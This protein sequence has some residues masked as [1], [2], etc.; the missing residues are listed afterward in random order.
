MT[1]LDGVDTGSG[2]RKTLGPE[3]VIA[4]ILVTVNQTKKNNHDELERDISKSNITQMAKRSK[5]NSGPAYA[6]MVPS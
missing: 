5:Q 1:I 4:M 2:S 3:I 6:H